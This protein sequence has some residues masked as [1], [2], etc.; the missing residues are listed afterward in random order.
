MY[1]G[2]AYLLYC[3]DWLSS[4]MNQY[5]YLETD[6]ISKAD[7]FLSHCWIVNIGLLTFNEVV[8]SIVQSSSRRT[9]I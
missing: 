7:A 1:R 2:Y 5:I 3:V 9:L 4:D 6:I 8:P